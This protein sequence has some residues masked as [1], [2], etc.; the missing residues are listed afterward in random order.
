MTYSPTWTPDSV[1]QSTVEPILR[2]G[3]VVPPLSDVVRVIEI[4][5]EDEFCTEGGLT[6]GPISLAF[7][8]WGTL[9]PSG[10]N[11][12]LILHALTGDAHATN[13]TRDEADR[14]W[15]QDLIGPGRPIDT[16]RY[17]VLCPNI[18]GGCRGSTGPSSTAPDGLPY[19]SRFPLITVRDQV[20]AEIRLAQMLGIRS[21]AAVIGGSMGGMRSLEWLCMEPNMVDTAVVL[22]VGC[23]A[24]PEQIALSSLQIR[25]IK[26][27][28][29]Y[30]GGDYQ[31]FGVAPD[32]GLA[33]ARGLGQLSYRGSEE[34]ERR[35]GRKPQDDR[36][37]RNGGLYAVESYLDHHGKKLAARFDAN[38]YI[39]L[40]QSM[41]HHD[42]GRGRGGPKAA[43]AGLKSQV[44][45]VGIS[46]DRLF[47]LPQQQSLA[48]LLPSLPEVEVVETDIGHDGFLVEY[49]K[50][51][52]IITRSLCS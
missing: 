1:Q 25:A 41:N 32:E 43:L 21:W 15:W 13:G 7:E 28:P 34:L 6:L 11:A 52:K 27:D 2:G 51:G 14:G 49:E 23:S 40:S 38:S 30:F 31:R 22:A 29:N 19:G 18:L 50:V 12:V 8:T 48:D 3:A 37:P 9:S 24:S 42:I 16:D 44:T 35:F 10:S 47:P 4:F 46:S 26:N 45:V 36:D 17:F 33:I 20:R 39:V 5:E